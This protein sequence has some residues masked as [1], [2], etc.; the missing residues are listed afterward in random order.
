[1]R[2][3]R[4]SVGPTPKRGSSRSGATTPHPCGIPEC[5]KLKKAA[6][7]ENCDFPGVGPHSLRRASITLRQE[8]GGSAIEASKLAGHSKVDVTGEY[9]LVQLK[10][11]EELT[12]KADPGNNGEKG[13]ATQFILRQ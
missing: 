13:N 9:T 12:R 1:M 4:N 10:R 11:Q 3:H 8:V 5:V 7:D 6:E 2:G